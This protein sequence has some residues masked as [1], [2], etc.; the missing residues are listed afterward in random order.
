MSLKYKLKKKKKRKMKLALILL[1]FMKV[2]KIMTN[3][4]R[5][6]GVN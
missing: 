4:I 2:R 1:K 6:V 3:K 5:K